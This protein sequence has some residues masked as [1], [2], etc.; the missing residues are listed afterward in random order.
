MLAVIIKEIKGFFRAGS[1]LFFCIFFPSLMVFLL[2]NLLENLDIS[3]YEIGKITLGYY[4]EDGSDLAEEY[5]KD[6][7]EQDILT[8]KHFDSM[9]KAEAE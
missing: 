3:D 9:E 6:L 1:Q 5:F 2:G 8:L 7:E 4:S